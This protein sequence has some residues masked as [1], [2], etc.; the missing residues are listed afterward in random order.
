VLYAYFGL[1]SPPL[2]ISSEFLPM[3]CSFRSCRWV[4]VSSPLFPSPHRHLRRL[5]VN[6]VAKHDL[7]LLLLC[8][9]S[10]MYLLSP[11][12]PL[13]PVTVSMPAAWPAVTKKPSRWKLSFRKSGSKAA[14]SSR[15]DS[16]SSN[17]ISNHGSA[18]IE[19][20]SN[21]IMGLNAPV[22]PPLQLPPSSDS[23]VIGTPAQ[24]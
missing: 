18:R 15:S 11:P 19:H 2:C 8:N 4:L 17:S 6:S 5:L 7:P 9:H 23:S 3:F 22:S 21:H 16:Q 20:M 24:G 14:I 1:P 12:L 10:R 13:I